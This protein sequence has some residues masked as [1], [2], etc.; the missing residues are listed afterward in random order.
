MDMKERKGRKQKAD[1]ESRERRRRVENGID[2]N[3][4]G[5]GG[6]IKESR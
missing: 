6:K 4:D 3:R 2:V 1:E 5:K